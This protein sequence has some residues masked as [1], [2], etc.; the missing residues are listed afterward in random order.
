MKKTFKLF[1]KNLEPKKELKFYWNK[2]K[3]PHVAQKRLIL[4]IEI[5]IQTK[6]EKNW[7]KTTK[8][9]LAYVQFWKTKLHRGRKRRWVHELLK[10]ACYINWFLTKRRLKDPKTKKLQQKKPKINN[11]IT[12]YVPILTF[13][14]LFRL[15]KTLWNQFPRFTFQYSIEKNIFLQKTNYK[16]KTGP[17]GRKSG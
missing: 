13:K 14:R 12:N 1:F 10:W 15:C 3:V 5:K 8:I 7:R 17:L 9:G 4:E 2:L 6:T 11:K 16:Q